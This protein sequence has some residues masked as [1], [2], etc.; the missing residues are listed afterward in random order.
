MY[1]RWSIYHIGMHPVH[2]L[3]VLIMRKCLKR[4]HLIYVSLL[5]VCDYEIESILPSSIQLSYLLRKISFKGS[6]LHEIFP[7]E[8]KMLFYQ[9]EGY[10]WPHCCMNNLYISH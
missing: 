1:I 6:Y 3:L 9:G 5:K 2:C 7:V 10:L 8:A 4:R